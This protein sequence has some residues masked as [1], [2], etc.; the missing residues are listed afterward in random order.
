MA[1]PPA[2]VVLQGERGAGKT[3]TAQEALDQAEALGMRRLVACCGHDA[4]SLGPVL[5][6]LRGGVEEGDVRSSRFAK[7]LHAVLWGPEG[8]WRPRP[9]SSVEAGAERHLLFASLVDLMARLGPTACVLDDVHLADPD[10]AEFL[11]F[12][13][14][15]IPATLMLVVTYRREELS[16]RSPI[17]GLAAARSPGLGTLVLELDALALEEPDPAPDPV[18]EPEAAPEGPRRPGRKGYGTALSPRE[19]E[20]TALASRGL[21]NI[22][23]ADQLFLSR[24]TVEAHISS[25]M[26]K[27][28]VRRRG[29][30]AYRVHEQQAR[31]NDRY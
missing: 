25:S 27:L 20:V 16:P 30:L 10:T 21:T 17:L 24:R 7:V 3:R 13:V 6:A 23:I 26:R 14:P 2:L 9:G 18:I 4:P 8:G 12:L 29:G 19:A 31:R 15:Q 28:G 5:D 11:R 22:E 1:A